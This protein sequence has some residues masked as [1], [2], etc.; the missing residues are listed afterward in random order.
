MA[1]TVT[2][3]YG[4]IDYLQQHIEIGKLLNKEKEAETWVKDFK[5]RAQQAGKDIKKSHRQ[6]RNCFRTGKIR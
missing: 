6:G 3:T 4:K 1:P 2:F 5:E